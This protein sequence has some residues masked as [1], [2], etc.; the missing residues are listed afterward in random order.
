RFCDTKAIIEVWYEN[1]KISQYEDG[2]PL[3][4]WQKTGTLAKYKGTQLFGLENQTSQIM[5][6]QLQVLSCKPSQW[7]EK[8]T[9]NML[10]E[11]HLK[12]RTI[13]TK[14]YP[15]YHQFNDRD[16]SSSPKQL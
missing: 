10:Y 16:W 14:L 12:R 5:L 3:K 6:R 15:S 7:N 1:Q 8:D 9:I 4:V 11:Y 2:T 13:A